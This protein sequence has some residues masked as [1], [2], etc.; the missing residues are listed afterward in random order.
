MDTKLNRTKRLQT[1]RLEIPQA[2][3][4]NWNKIEEGGFEYKTKLS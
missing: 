2:S 3:Q 1:L 4:N